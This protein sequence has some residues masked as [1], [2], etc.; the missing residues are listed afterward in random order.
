MLT[1]VGVIVSVLD[2]VIVIVR[3]KVLVEDLMTVLM[4]VLRLGQQ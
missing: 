3:R 4:T 1:G 2:L